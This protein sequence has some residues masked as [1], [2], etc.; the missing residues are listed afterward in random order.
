[1]SM[2]EHGDYWGEDEEHITITISTG[3]RQWILKG[4]ADEDPRTRISYALNF[5]E[6]L[7][8]E[9]VSYVRNY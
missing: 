7:N 3:D 1:M 8:F 2:A 5:L 6:W 4:S 9:K